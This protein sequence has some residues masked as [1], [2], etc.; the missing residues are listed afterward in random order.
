VKISYSVEQITLRLNRITIFLC[1]VFSLSSCEK[2]QDVKPEELLRNNSTFPIGAALGDLLKANALY[3]GVV[4]KEHTSVTVENAMKWFTT[5]PEQDRFYF[6]DADYIVSFAQ[7]QKKR[8][9]GHTLLWYFFQEIDW[10]KNFSG[11]S[12]AW[13]TMIKNHIQTEVSHFKGKVS[14]WDVVNEAFHENTGLLRKDDLDPSDFDNGCIF[15]RKVGSDY[16]ARA[17]QYA[18]EADPDALL[19]YNDYGQEWDPKKIEAIVAM[20][21][22]FKKRGIPIHGL[23]LQMHTHTDA[24]N[25][26]IE[27]AMRQLASTGLQIHISELDISANNA[28]S[29]SFIYTES[30]QQLHAEKYKFLVSAYKRIVPAS[31]QYGITTWNVG[32]GDSWIRTYLKRLDYPLLF[33]ENY[34]RKKTYQGFLDGLKL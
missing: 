17:F 5:H 32:D 14:S 8:V 16:M 2:N 29:S 1:L 7:S 34:N 23:G 4:T 10:V 21:T 31:Q 13:E 9:H 11:D 30:I 12:A 18:H 19:F 22:D 28:N 24:S 20:V 33:D 15:A 27:N 6:D 26:G 25:G 3:R